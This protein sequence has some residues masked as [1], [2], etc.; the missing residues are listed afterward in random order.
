MVSRKWLYSYRILT[1]RLREGADAPSPL[2]NSLTASSHQHPLSLN[3][4][5]SENDPKKTASLLTAGAER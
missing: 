4:E 1:A 5:L 3:A 2:A